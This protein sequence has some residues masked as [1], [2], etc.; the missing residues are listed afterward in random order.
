MNIHWHLHWKIQDS[1]QLQNMRFPVWHVEF[2]CWLILKIVLMMIGRYF[3]LFLFCFI[4]PHTSFSPFFSLLSTM[5]QVGT[6]GIE[7]EYTDPN[8]KFR[9]ATYLPEVAEDQGWTK[10]EALHSLIRKSGFEGKISNSLLSQLKVTRYQSS[11]VELHYKEYIT[12]KQK[13]N[14]MD[15]NNWK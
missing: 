15:L 6:H 3:C 12:L 11:K 8:G 4:I 13:S 1:L 14:K 9:H 10:T 5:Y 7:I 2:L